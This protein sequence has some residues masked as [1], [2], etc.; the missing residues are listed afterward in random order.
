MEKNKIRKKEGSIYQ[1][2]T[3]GRW[4]GTYIKG[5]KTGK[6]GKQV[7]DREYVYADT[8]EE[9]ERK[10]EAIVYQIKN[11]LDLERVSKDTVK[12]VVEDWLWNN[13]K[14]YLQPRT[15]E[16]Y[17]QT[18]RNYI[19]PHL[20]HMKI[21]ELKSSNVSDMIVAMQN[22]KNK[23]S[24]TGYGLSPRTIELTK[25]VL[26]AALDHAVKYN[27]V[28]S[29][30]AKD[31]TVNKMVNKLMNDKKAK[32]VMED[33]SKSMSVEEIKCFM[34]E[35]NKLERYSELIKL[36]FALALRPGEALGLTWKRIKFES[37]QIEIKNDLARNAYFD[38][39]R[40]KT[41]VKEMDKLKNISSIR[42]LVVPD[43]IMDMLKELKNKQEIESKRTF[44]GKRQYVDEGFVFTTIYGTALEP[45]NYNRLFDKIKVSLNLQQYH[46]HSLRHTAIEIMKSRKFDYE[47]MRYYIGHNNPDITGEYLT[48]L[49][50]GINEELA[51]VESIYKEILELLP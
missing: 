31:E 16:S 38:S 25:V 20:G 7:L 46:P 40:N 33:V 41:T 3:D 39:D 37:N 42:T 29:N 10:L 30:V 44:T 8:K 5:R 32:E 34:K 47:I 13:A 23:K 51:K 2:G 11:N 17:E 19:I 14:L 49:K 36:Q 22:Q 12:Q 9:A 48:R 45:R 28:K 18:V 4:V 1:R 15:F 35:V 21:G 50:E 24:K 6:N 27:L 26:G 43:F